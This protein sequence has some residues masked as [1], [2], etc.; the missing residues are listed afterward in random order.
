MTLTITALLGLPL[1]PVALASGD[2]AKHALHKLGKILDRCESGR[3][4]AKTADKLA[5]AQADCVSELNEFFREN[6]PIDVPE[7]L[8]VTFSDLIVT[9]YVVIAPEQFG[10]NI[11]QNDPGPGA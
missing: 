4:K 3:E 11:K 5:D 8:K 10:W 7:G 1:T 2:D 9:G 6:P